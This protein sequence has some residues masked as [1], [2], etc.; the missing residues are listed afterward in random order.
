MGCG[1][2]GSNNPAV[3]QRLAQRAAANARPHD[4]GP[5]APGYYSGP[6]QPAAPKPKQK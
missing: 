4:S 6:E 2:G 3:Q 1:C 5:N